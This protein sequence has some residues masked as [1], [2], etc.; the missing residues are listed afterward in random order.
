VDVAQ[1]LSGIFDWVQCCIHSD[2]AW[3]DFGMNDQWS[4]AGRALPSS[5]KRPH[6]AT[7]TQAFVITQTVKHWNADKGLTADGSVAEQLPNGF[8]LP[9]RRS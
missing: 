2:R 1:H 4:V 7:L 8:R 3:P 6:T 5:F 9:P